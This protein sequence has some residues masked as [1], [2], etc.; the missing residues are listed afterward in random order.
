LTTPGAPGGWTS[1]EPGSGSWRGRLRL[2]DAGDATAS[3]AFDWAY[4]AADDLAALADAA[5]LRI[6][7]QWTEAGRWFASLA[8]A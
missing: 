3:R 2:R 5:T 8:P 1:P 6:C 4:V 7:I